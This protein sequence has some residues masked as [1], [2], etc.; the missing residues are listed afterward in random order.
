MHIASAS[1]V[2]LAVTASS[3]CA[4]SPTPTVLRR[5]DSITVHHAGP[6]RPDTATPKRARAVEDALVGKPWTM[7]TVEAALP[8]FAEDFQPL[9]DMRASAAYRLLAAQNL[10]RRFLLET[11]GA[12]ERLQR[13][14]A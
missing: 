5:L 9:T 14:V 13:E 2:V 11:T 3:L 10:L 7:E 12:G 6:V 1:L 8:A 4:Q